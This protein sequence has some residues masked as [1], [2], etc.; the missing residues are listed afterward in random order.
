MSD[1]VVCNHMLLQSLENLPS[2]PDYR[3]PPFHMM[4]HIA[5]FANTGMDTSGY[6]PKAIVTPR[7][8]DSDPQ[9]DP[10]DQ[11]GTNSKL[12]TKKLVPVII[13]IV[14]KMLK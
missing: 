12:T 4:E 10:P 13:I 5:Q 3:G 11:G 7:A 2:S 9:G 1:L 6:N 14:L 8:V